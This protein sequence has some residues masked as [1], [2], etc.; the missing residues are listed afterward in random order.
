VNL[1]KGKNLQKKVEW[2]F[3]VGKNL[4]NGIGTSSKELFAMIVD[5]KGWK[6]KSGVIEK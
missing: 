5:L 2:M 1:K 4:L 6:E 3:I